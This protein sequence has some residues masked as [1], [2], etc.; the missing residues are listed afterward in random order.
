MNLGLL[1]NQKQV[2]H[3]TPGKKLQPYKPQFPS[4]RDQRYIEKTKSFTWSSE[5]LR[6]KERIEACII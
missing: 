4:L 6:Y 5:M 1:Y 2:N 3:E